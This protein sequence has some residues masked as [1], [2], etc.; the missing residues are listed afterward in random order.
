MKRKFI[1]NKIQIS[2]LQKL[3]NNVISLKYIR[4]EKFFNFYIA[5]F[6]IAKFSKNLL[7]FL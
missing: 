3:L 1:K 6:Y 5:N 7:K 2:I 4:K